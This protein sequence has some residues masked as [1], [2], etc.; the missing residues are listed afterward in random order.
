MK[1]CKCEGMCH[2][3]RYSIKQVEAIIQKDIKDQ[4]DGFNN[5]QL[6]QLSEIIKRI[7][8]G[9]PL[10][11]EVWMKGFRAGFDMGYDKGNNNEY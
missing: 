1:D 4:T 8:S 6:S 10:L 5:K 2:C 3:P 11:D 7:L 9:S